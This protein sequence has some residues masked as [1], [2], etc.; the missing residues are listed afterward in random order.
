M[1]TGSPPGR[2]N[3]YMNAGLSFGRFACLSVSDFFCLMIPRYHIPSLFPLRLCAFLSMLVTSGVG[4]V[5]A[6]SAHAA[7]SPEKLK[8]LIVTGGHGFEKQ[9]FFKMFGDDP[10]ITFTAAEHSK[11]NA[12]VYD[13]DDLLTYDV[14]VLYDMPKEITDAQKKNFL[15]L[16]ENGTGVVVLHHALVSY[17]NW[18]DYERIIGG[19]YPEPDPSKPGTVTEQAGYQHDVDIPVVI[20]ATNHPIVAGLADFTINDE[21]YWGFRVQPDVTSLFTTTHAKSGKPLAWT[22]ME[23][24]SRLVYIQLGHGPSAF[25]NSNYRK[26]LA[27]SIQWAANRRA[28]GRS[29]SGFTPQ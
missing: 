20:L 24:K 18:P 2:M 13:R 19:R 17:P 14:V 27:Q 8:V 7:P 22:R 4:I 25:N 11:T 28:T 1:T 9:P 16:F 6:V 5:L 29:R 12:S 21:I 3:S 15:S 23:L 10:A 26:L